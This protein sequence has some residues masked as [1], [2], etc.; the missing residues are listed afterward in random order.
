MI[1][2]IESKNR[3]AQQLPYPYNISLIIDYIDGHFTSK[4]PL[5]L[6]RNT[7]GEEV[8]FEH[9]PDDETT[10]SQVT[11][12]GHLLAAIINDA[13][14]RDDQQAAYA[15]SNEALVLRMAPVTLSR[16]ETL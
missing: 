14:T 10:K 15:G 1:R 11:G 7:T 8:W 4:A 12:C 9:A 5:K 13:V 6:C 3:A 2:Q 16:G